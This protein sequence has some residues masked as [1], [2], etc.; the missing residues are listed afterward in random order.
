MDSLK[1]QVQKQL[2]RHSWEVLILAFAI[3]YLLVDI[4]LFKKNPNIIININ[5][6]VNPF[7]AITVAVV[8]YL[9]TRKM[10]SGNPNRVL[11]YGLSIG[12]ALW[13][14]GELIYMLPVLFDKDTA[15]PG[16]PDIFW[17]LG[18]LPMFYAFMQ[19]ERVL[20]VKLNL[21]SKILS[22]LLALVVVGFTGYFMVLPAVRVFNRNYI[23]FSML[24]LLYPL[25]DLTLLL[26][27]LRTFFTFIQGAYGHARLW[28]A[29]GFFVKTF[30]DLTY[31]YLMS[32][33]RYYH[34]GLVDFRSVFLVDYTYTAGYLLFL[35]GLVILWRFASI[36]SPFIKARDLETS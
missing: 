33:H 30:S 17:L 18:Y 36:S 7:L 35:V 15:Y 1:T 22:W 21:N 28:V 25:L 14:V 3:A 29:I 31:H 16:P 11:W 2:S 8:A 4:F 5:K 23:L 27:V 26:M 10:G 6:I 12:W 19:H 9:L 24:N 20:P 32:I 34:Y 13:A